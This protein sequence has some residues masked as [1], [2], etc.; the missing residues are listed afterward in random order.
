MCHARPG[1]TELDDPS[2]EAV[3]VTRATHGG[4]DSVHDASPFW[5]T[6]TAGKMRRLVARPP[7]WQKGRPDDTKPKGRRSRSGRNTRHGASGSRHAPAMV[8]C[9]G[10]RR[11]QEGER[12]RLARLPLAAADPGGGRPWRAEIF[13]GEQQER[14]R[15]LKDRL[16]L[17]TD[18]EM[19][20][21]LLDVFIENQ[22]DLP[23]PSCT[24]LEDGADERTDFICD[25]VPEQDDLDSYTSQSLSAG[26]ESTI[27]LSHP[28][29]MDSFED[30]AEAELFSGTDAQYGGNTRHRRPRTLALI[31]HEGRRATP[32][33]WELGGGN[34]KLEPCGWSS[35]GSDPKH[36]ET[37]SMSSSRILHK[38]LERQSSSD[39]EIIAVCIGDESVLTIKEE[40][41]DWF[42]LPSPAAS[43]FSGTTVTL[44]HPSRWVMVTGALG[45]HVLVM[46][47]R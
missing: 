39:R 32:E 4:G 5:P 12:V 31:N 35:R 19:A 20:K 45:G 24:F 25:S 14:W 23:G 8:A 17:K 26:S 13:I 9:E 41:E 38:G 22:M 34:C 15:C 18:E 6:P 29:S 43:A 21:V 7:P 33:G 2:I 16:E 47:V 37:E 10:G 42:G 44:S 3:A 1:Q 11:G 28:S 30:E 46:G 36:K 27:T 40:Q